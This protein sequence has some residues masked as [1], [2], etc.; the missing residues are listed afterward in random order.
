MR[1]EAPRKALLGF[2]VVARLLEDEEAGCKSFN[3]LKEAN[4]SREDEA[5]DASPW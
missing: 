1:E 2:R 5:M 3:T 4:S